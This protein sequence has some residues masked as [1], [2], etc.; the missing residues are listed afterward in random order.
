MEGMESMMVSKVPMLKPTEFD[1]W[2]LRIKQYM[3]LTDYSMWDIVE[4]GPIRREA[5][6]GGVVPP[7]RTDAE[8]KT[9]QSEMKALSTLL[10]AIPNEYQH[11]FATCENAKVLWE[12]LE[13]RFAGSKSSK[14]NQKAVLKQQY[15][16]FMSSK[17]ESMTQTF[18]RFNKLIGELA[19]V[20]VKIDN[21]DLNRKFLR[22]LGEEWVIYTVPFRQSDNLEDKELDDLYNDLRVF[23]AEVEAKKKPV[24]YSHN[25]ALFSGGESITNGESNS[26][27]PI[28]KQETEGDSVME[29]LFSSHAGV[30]LVNEDLDQIHADDLEEMDLKW[31]MAMI[32]VRVNRGSYNN[33]QQNQQ[34]NQ[35][36]NQQN[37]QNQ[38]QNPLQHNQQQFGQQQQNQ[39]M[40]NQQQHHFSSNR[41]NNNNRNPNSGSSQALVSQEGAGFDWSDQAEDQVQ[42]QAFMAEIKEE[43]ISE[44]PQEVKSKLCSSSCLE[45]VRK[46]R[47]H[48]QVMCDSIKKLELSR[49]ESSL[50]IANLEDQIKAYQANEVQYGYD[51]NYW[52]WEKKELE[53]KISRIS[54]E[55]EKTREDL[56]KAN[57]NLEKYSKSSKALDELLKSQVHDDL[58]KGIGYHNTPPPY[59]NNYIPPT[60]DILDRLDKSDLRKA[61]LEVDPLLNDSEFKKDDPHKPDPKHEKDLQKDC[62]TKPDVKSQ[63]GTSKKKEKEVK[64]GNQRNW[65]QQWAQK[66]GIDLSKINKPKPCFICCNPNHLAK[67]CYFNPVNQRAFT[68]NKFVGSFRTNR[69]NSSKENSSDKA[70]HDK[71]LNMKNTKV[72]RLAKTKS[73]FSRMPKSKS[74]VKKVWVPKAVE[75]QK[76]TAS[77]NSTAKSTSKSEPT[78]KQVWMPKAAEPKKSTASSIPTA[79]ST[80][81]KKG[82]ASSIPT[83]D[84]TNSNHSAA[85]KAIL[86]RYAHTPILK[87]KYSSHEIP[88]TDYLLK[89]NRLTEDNQQIGKSIWH[90]DSGCSRH[91][92]GNK[93]ILQNFKH[94]EGGHVAFGD[95]P[96]GGKIKGKG[97]ISKDKMSFE[98]VFYVEQLRYNLLSVSQ[99]CDKKF[100][101]FFTDSECLILAP[102]FKIDENLV[103]LR[104]P[105]K[106]NVYCLDLERIPSNQS[107]NCLFSKASHDESNLWHRR[108][109]HMNFKNMNKLVKNNLVRGLPRKEFFCND[110]CVACLK[111]KQHKSSHKSKEVNS[112]SSPL[113]LIHMDL[114]GPT[115]V[116]SIGKKSYCLVIVDDFSRFTWVYFLKTKDETS[117]L[118]KSFV[119]RVENQSNLKVKVI[120]SDNGTEFKNSDINSFCDEKGIEKQY[121]APRTPQHNGV[122]E[123]RNRTL[124]EAARSLL[125]D[126][127]LPITFWAEA[128]NTACYVQNRTLVVKSQGKTPYEI[129]KKKK[130]FIGFFKPFG[131]P[132]TI[133]NT[134][135]QLGKFDSKSEEGFLVGYATQC[136]GYRV[137]NSVTRIIEESENVKCNEHTPNAQGT[138]PNWLFDIDSF[139]NSFKT[140][141]QYCTG[142]STQQVSEVQPQFVMLPIP[143]IDPAEFCT[144]DNQEEGDITPQAG[145][146]PVETLSQPQSS[147]EDESTPEQADTNLSDSLQEEAPYQ[148]R[149]QKNHPTTLVIGDVESPMLTRHKSKQ[150]VTSSSHLSLISCFLS[151]EEPKKA[152]DAMKDPSWIEAMQEELLQFVLQHVWDLVDLPSGHR[153]IGTKWIFRNKKDERGIVIKNKARL[154][155]QGYT[156]EEGIDYDEVFAPVARIEAIRLFLAYASFKNFKVYQMDVKSAFLY[157]KIEEEVYVCQPPGFEDPR[158]PDRV[159]KLNKALYGLHQAPRAWYDTLS[160]YL[161]ENDF[162]RGVIDKT[163]F[164]KREKQEILLVQIYVDDIIFGSTKSSMCK[165]FEDLMH[166]KFK[167]S[168]MG[169]LTFFL[170]LQVAQKEDGIFIHQSKYVKDILHKFGFSDV[171][172]ASTPME[173]HKPLLWI[174]KDRKLMFQVQPKDS[175][176]QAVKRIFRYLKG[177]SKFGL[178]YPH[179]SPFD[180]IAYTDSDYGGANMDRKSTTGGCQFLGS[181]LVSWQCKKQTSVST[182]TAEAEYIAAASC[183]SQVLWIQNQILDYGLTFLNTPIYIDNSSAIKEHNRVAYLTKDNSNEDFHEII[184]FVTSS[185]I[186]TAITINPTIYKGHMQQFWTNATSEELNG[187]QTITSKVGGRRLLIT[188]AKI[189]AHLH[190]DD[191]NG[192]TSFSISDL[193]ENLQRMGYEGT[194]GNLKLDKSKFSPQWKFLVHT[195]IHSISK[196]ST[197]WNEFSS[198]IAYALICLANNQRFNFSKMIFDDIVAHIKAPLPKTLKKLFLYPRF[199]QVFINAE[200]PGLAI[201]LDIYKGVDPSPKMFAF[202]RKTNKGFSGS[203]TPLFSTMRRVTHP[204]DEDSGLQPNQSSTPPEILPTSSTSQSP[205]IPTSSTPTPSLTKDFTRHSGVPSSSMPSIPEP[206]SPSLEHSPMDIPQ[207]ESPR[208]SP[209]SQKVPSKEEAGHVDCKAQPTAHV[210]GAEQDRLNINKTFSMATQDEQSSRGPGC[211]E[212]MGVA[213]ASARQRTTTNFSKDPSRAG[214]TP[215]HGED[216]YTSDEMMVAMGK[217]AADC[218]EA[219][220]LAKSQAVLISDL[221]KVVKVQ[222]RLMQAGDTLLQEHDNRLAIHASRI[223]S[224]NM[225]ISILRRMLYSFIAQKKRNPFQATQFTFSKGESSQAKGESFQPKQ[226]QQDAQQQSAQQEEVQVEKA[227]EQQSA[228]EDA[229]SEK[230]LEKEKEAVEVLLVGLPNRGFMEALPNRGFMADARKV[231]SSAAVQT[232]QP[233]QQNTTTADPKGKGIMIEEPKKKAAPRIPEEVNA[234]LSAAKIQEILDQDEKEDAEMNEKL[235]SMKRKKS[236]AKKTPIAKKRKI[237]EDADDTIIHWTTVK[238]GQKDDLKVIR[239]NGK[240]DVYFNLDKF[241]SVCTRKD[242]DDFNR[243]GLELYGADFFGKSMQKLNT[244]VK[245][246]MESLDRTYSPSYMN[247][248]ALGIILWKVYT[249]SEVVMLRLSDG[250]DEFHLFERE[251][252]LNLLRIEGILKKINKHL[253][254]NELEKQYVARVKEMKRKIIGE[255]VQ[256]EEAYNP[257][258]KVEKWEVISQSNRLYYKLDRHGGYKDFWKTFS[259]LLEHCSI[260]NLKE[261]FE[262]GMAVYG[263]VLNEEEVED[264]MVDKIKK[265]LEWLCMLFDVNRV[266]DLVVQEVEI[267]NQWVLYESCGVY[268]VVCDGSN[269]EYYL[270]EGDYNHSLVKLQKMI[271]KGLSCS[272]SSEMGADLRFEILTVGIKHTFAAVRTPQQNGVVERRNRTL[273]EAA[274]T[275]LAYSKLPIFLWAEAVDTACYTQNRSIVNNRCFVLNDREDRHKLQMVMESS[276]VKFDP[277]AEMASKHDSSEPGLTGVLAVNLVNPDHVTPTKQKDGASTSTNNLSDLDILFENFYNEYF[278]SSS[279]DSTTTNNSSYIHRETTV[280]VQEPVS[281]SGPS[282]STIS[283]DTSSVESPQVQNSIIPIP[284]NQEIIPIVDSSQIQEADI[285]SSEDISDP[286]PIRMESTFDDYSEDLQIVPSFESLKKV[287]ISSYTDS[288]Y[289]LQLYRPLPQTTKWTRDHPLHQII[290][291]PNAPVQTR[292]ATAN[293]CLFAAFLSNVEPLKVA[294]A[295]ADPDW[296]MAM[297]EKINQFVRLK[298]WRLVPRPEGKSII[299]TKWIFKNK[300]DGDNIVVRNK[301]RLVA[302]G[303]R[304][305]EGI[306]YNE[307]FAP[308]ARIEA[309]RMFLAYA[310]HKDFTVYQMDVK[311]AFL[312][313]IL[314]EEALYGLK[315]APR[316]WYDSLSQFLVESGYSKG[317]ID[318]TLFIKREGEHIMLVQIYVDDIIFGSTCP[319]FCNTFSK[320]MMTRYEMSMMG[321]LNFFLGL[322]VKQLSA[323][324]FINQAK[325]IKDILKKYNLEN[326]KIMKTPMSPSCALDSDPDG[327]AVDVTTYRGMIGSLV[328]LTASRPDIMFSTCLCARYQSKPKESHLKAV[329]RIFRYLKGTVNLGLWY[330]KGSGYELT[331]YT[332]ADHGGCKLDRKSTTGHIQSRSRIA[333]HF[334]RPKLNMW[335]LQAVVL[336]LFGCVPSAIAISCNP[337]QHTKTKHIDIKYHFIK[338]HVEKGTIELYF[339]N[340][341]FQLA[342]LFTKALDEKRFKFLITKLGMRTLKT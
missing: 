77:G 291:D 55:L 169:E 31:Q 318:N 123:R 93:F 294:D 204:Q 233:Q 295:L 190:L 127:K 9:R 152:H 128:V 53:L 91:M 74:T 131:C 292:S 60:T 37:Q 27:T 220:T 176:L 320:L 153:A 158:Y 221:Q 17:N 66:H 328:Y 279:S 97:K 146:Q 199:I 34:N 231:V 307:T 234:Q 270:V 271:E 73:S 223:M 278:G 290:G 170:G 184:D 116:M 246:I 143:T 148:T 330:P 173:T 324:I 89:L 70:G 98:D 185:H 191:L 258:G 87:T 8:R 41:A 212:T 175:H 209:N 164:I 36:Q 2:K 238:A 147:Q 7:P 337:V 202:L 110:N 228:K 42:N 12:A 325:Y 341:E 65:N 112:I 10:L 99:V 276:N 315:Q 283:E 25:T 38:Q 14:R 120:R 329:K 237:V 3:L 260:D 317:K 107:L 84:S 192:I 229:E 63:E 264:A 335:L 306:D 313:G 274:R 40:H 277:Y 310:A 285:G 102:G 138:G 166:K 240:E 289:D 284:E 293:E 101:V 298:V 280:N 111:G 218:T 45:T 266:Q 19:T 121:S 242:L 189:R 311:T 281:I 303:Y 161:L 51:L 236:I 122:A 6:E 16:N 139:T 308:V 29:A 267:V 230:R 188:E 88:S 67:H 179:D 129:F 312:N 79:N 125:A 108:M 297:Q 207:R 302:K 287:P 155:A 133:L 59:N 103:L 243:V 168:A 211:Q 296:F 196:K 299:D 326:A 80:N 268:A 269:C 286:I 186:A 162:T 340:T 118:I 254:L 227:I 215:E 282:T 5:G 180:L 22:S 114:F 135:S 182:S 275:M 249:K 224:Q 49:R 203:V 252:N 205:Q 177:H 219:L 213:G 144:N 47:D 43:P 321:E 137:F 11:Q 18:D 323:G 301:A 157:G 226:Q 331:G 69:Q 39:N 140:S 225:Q 130:P 126:S 141:E 217:I 54:S 322:Q 105:R 201:P 332:D 94:F 44:I 71:Y 132:C 33:Q 106:D 56:N 305:Q 35:Q 13:K 265:A 338:D 193:F 255:A 119:T 273:V 85:L 198:T 150:A 64:R 339:V 300:K 316:E 167:I 241:I 288:S 81:S 263:E 145:D 208:V 197:S 172:P 178:W 309:I 28:S 62:N 272:I 239:R 134:K 187:V 159:Y 20:G 86:K 57:E 75:S 248:R 174:Q 48:N 21:D 96:K 117:G 232:S 216:R 327:K 171:K 160:T 194:I 109:C 247:Q 83:A 183:C 235:S 136:K 195:L 214:N 334:Q 304:Q 23:E 104:S 261:I 210:Q 206:L 154:V 61:A 222:Q 142:P 319:N 72:I 113:Q 52:N 78:V 76:S 259:D 24:G 257:F 58:K 181:R 156:Q 68:K 149:T 92:T 32:T 100:G 95:N 115:N 200:L 151:Q 244:T 250:S 4:N 251:Y 50:V 256:E 262:H 15:E 26:S 165:E 124:I 342:D 163:L 46:Y 90:I 253:K 336:R 314:K 82:T 245:M 333:C 1:M 30:P